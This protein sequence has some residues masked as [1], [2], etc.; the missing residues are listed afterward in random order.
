MT[1]RCNGIAECANGE[2]EKL[3][4]KSLFLFLRSYIPLLKFLLSSLH[5]LYW[6]MMCVITSLL[7]LRLR[8]CTDKFLILYMHV[9]I[10]VPVCPMLVYELMSSEYTSDLSTANVTVVFL[11]IS[12][13]LCL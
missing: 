8:L 13:R 9:C 7:I 12:V 5:F 1:W 2:D 11:F 4:G 10:M 6:M 3:C